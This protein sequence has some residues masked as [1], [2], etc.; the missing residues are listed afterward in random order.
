MP[1]RQPSDY[2]AAPLL[3]V[4]SFQQRCYYW[5]SRRSHPL[6]DTPPIG[7]AGFAAEVVG[8]TGVRDGA[9]ASGEGDRHRS[10]HLARKRGAH[11]SDPASRPC[12]ALTSSYRV[13]S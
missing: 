11:R 4:E 10:C 6:A 9:H 7:W 5:L 8:G 2:G 13:R 1:D 12:V 3:K